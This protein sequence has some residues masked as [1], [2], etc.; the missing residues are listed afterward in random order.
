MTFQLVWQAF[1]SP[2]IFSWLGWLCLLLNG[3][4]RKLNFCEELK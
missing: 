1:S 3:H 4:V 2:K